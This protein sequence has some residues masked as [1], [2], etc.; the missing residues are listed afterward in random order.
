MTYLKVVIANF[1]PFKNTKNELIV[2]NPS[3]G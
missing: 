1:E 2:E 3:T